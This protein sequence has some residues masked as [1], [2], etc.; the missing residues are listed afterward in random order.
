MRTDVAAI[1]KDRWLW[2]RAWTSNAHGD[3]GCVEED[4]DG[5]R[6]SEQGDTLSRKHFL[7]S[8]P[9]TS[10]SLSQSCRPGPACTPTKDSSSWEYCPGSACTM[11]EED[12]EPSPQILPQTSSQ[13]CNTTLR[14]D[15]PK[16]LLDP[17][18]Q[19]QR[20]SA[21]DWKAGQESAPLGSCIFK[22]S[23]QLQSLQASHVSTQGDCEQPGHTES[24]SLHIDQCFTGRR[25]AY[26]TAT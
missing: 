25:R 17:A 22:D 8:S 9:R 26:T 3:S 1:N 20:S 16:S 21:S 11:F 23:G 12:Y 13:V 5:A 10:T 2:R 24:S 7:H 6:R 4:A 18:H 19:T 14:I 15:S